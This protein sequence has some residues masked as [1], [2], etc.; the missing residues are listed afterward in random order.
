MLTVAQVDLRRKRFVDE[1][2][3]GVE[4]LPMYRVGHGAYTYTFDTYGHVTNADT[5]L[6]NGRVGGRHDRRGVGRHGGEW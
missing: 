3:Y 6:R 2:A 1:G 5:S 4:E